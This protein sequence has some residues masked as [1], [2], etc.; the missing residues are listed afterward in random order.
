VHVPAEHRPFVAQRPELGVVL[1]VQL[2]HARFF[3]QRVNPDVH[4]DR[5]GL[6]ELPADEP[7]LPDRRDQDVRFRGNRGEPLRPGMRD[8]HGAVLAKQE[9]RHRL[10]DDVAAT[11]HDRPLPGE[12]DPVALQERDHAQGGARDDAREPEEQPAGVR[13]MKPVDVLRRV[14]RPENPVGIDAGRQRELHEDP[15]HRGVGVQGP[16]GV[17][18]RGFARG[19]GEA[20]GLGPHPRGTRGLLL[21]AHVG[22]RRRVLADQHHG[23]AGGHARALAE[24]GHAP[25][26]VVA[27]RSRRF[28]SVQSAGGHFLRFL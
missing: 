27:N 21:A 28:R 6:D 19:R 18:D 17:Q 1:A 4:H 3:G 11:E 23:Q 15:V 20:K 24:R 26:D 2:A 5:T 14:D 22:H 13:G 8:R 7:R 12:R 16:D 25:R 10:A 9:D